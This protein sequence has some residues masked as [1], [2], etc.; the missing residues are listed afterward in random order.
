MQGPFPVSACCLLHG[1]QVPGAEPE[2]RAFLAEGE[3]PKQQTRQ[4]GQ[5]LQPMFAGLLLLHSAPEHL[6]QG[7]VQVEHLAHRPGVALL[8]DAFGQPF[9][10]VG[11]AGRLL[12]EGRVPVALGVEAI[13][14]VVELG[15]EH[16]AGRFRGGVQVGARVNRFQDAQEVFEVVRQAVSLVGIEFRVRGDRALEAVQAFPADTGRGQGVVELAEIAIAVQKSEVGLADY[17]VVRGRVVVQLL[18]P[19]LHEMTVHLLDVMAVHDVQDLVPH[20]LTVAAATEGTE[21]QPHPEPVF[22]LLVVDRR[23]AAGEALLGVTEL[24]GLGVVVALPVELPDGGKAQPG[25]EQ[26]QCVRVPL[27]RLEQVMAEVEAVHEGP[28]ASAHLRFYD[29]VGELP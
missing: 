8:Q 16:A 11:D 20:F 15:A 26:G 22:R 25:V 7:Q 10:Q 5:G 1:L 23:K 18:V 12:S 27:C 28:G 17:D 3:V 14:L 9:T 13:E 4:L 19:F 21:H 29:L 2:L 24:P 6:L